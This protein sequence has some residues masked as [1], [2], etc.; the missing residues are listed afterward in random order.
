MDELKPLSLSSLR[1]DLTRYRVILNTEIGDVPLE[2]LCI[3]KTTIS[4]LKREGYT[5]VSDLLGLKL[6]GINGIGRNRAT[7][8]SAKLRSFFSYD[9]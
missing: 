8:L 1:D 3:D 2:T 9:L 5:R 6:E 7:I 4:I